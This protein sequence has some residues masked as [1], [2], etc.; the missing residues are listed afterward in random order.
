MDSEFPTLSNGRYKI[1]KCIGKGG[2]AAVFKCFDQ[3]LQVYRAVK[4]L[5]PDMVGRGNIRERFTTE[6]IAMANLVHPNIVH[7]YDH[8]LDG[9]AL[10]I[11]MEYLPHNSLQNFLD[12]NG[13]LS[14]SQAVTLMLD[15][16]SAVKKAHDNGIIHRDIK[17]DNILL[18][19]QGAKLTDF[20]LARI[21][22][23]DRRSTKTKAVMGTF[24]YMAPEQRLSAKK[25]NHQSDVYAVAASFFVMLTGL[26]PSD[27]FDEEEQI[28]LLASLNDSVKSIIRK[29]CQ[30]SLKSRYQN[31]DEFLEDLT[32]IEIDPNDKKLSL[33][34]EEVDAAENDITDLMSVWSEYTGL[35]TTEKETSPSDTLMFD[36]EAEIPED[37]T[38]GIGQS[39][40]ENSNN[41]PETIDT[42]IPEDLEDHKKNS[43]MLLVVFA[44]VLCLVGGLSFFIQ[45]L[46]KETSAIVKDSSEISPPEWNYEGIYL[47]VAPKTDADQRNFIAARRAMLN[48]EYPLAERLLAPLLK[49]HPEDPTTHSLAAILHV[50][51]G[52]MGMSADESRFAAKWSRDLETDLGK[53][54]Q[55]SDRSWREPEN[56]ENLISKWETIREKHNDPMVDISY[57]ISSRYMLGQKLFLSEV[58]QAKTNHPDWVVLISLEILALEHMG[59]TKELLTVV[60]NGIQ[61][62][63]TSTQLLLEKGKVLY[64][65]DK[66]ERAEEKLKEVLVLDG[67][68]ITARSLLAN[69]YI[70][71][72]KEAKRLEQFMISLG[73]TVAPFE[74][75]AFLQEHAIKLSNHGRLNEAEKVWRF[76]ISQAQEAKDYNRALECA[77]TALDAL[78]WIKPSK[79]WSRWTEELEEL[80][81]K[82]VYDADLRQ[83]YT[84]RLM[85]TEATMYARE[86]NVDKAKTILEQIQSLSEKDVPLNSKAFFVNEI[87]K[88]IALQQKDSETL[89]RILKQNQQSTS[90]NNC[91][92]L[93]LEAQIANALT[94]PSRIKNSLQRII[95]T[96]CTQNYAF[97]GLLVAKTRIWLAQILLNDWASGANKTKEVRLLVE[98]AKLLEAFNNEWPAADPSL[99]LMTIARALE[100][101]VK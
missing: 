97:N 23:S 82:P 85:W 37:E 81:A 36:L 50:L 64:K 1:E 13:T 6:A 62:F 24:P 52:R 88:E 48:G 25:T 16:G 22:T 18:S 68:L 56:R 11:V 90:E 57:L 73:D 98:A 71:Q 84:I 3:S 60:E 27:L 33:S 44:I 19:P 74:Q 28:E 75:L 76:C 10:F 42:P 40:G 79:E 21:D 61:S 96:E 86:G 26:D 34:N 89:E 58:R 80:L 49:S 77:S 100:E 55:L 35:S 94:D 91:S 30:A 17:P 7:V 70:E 78:P 9:S 15:V 2:M 46:N 8:G 14:L 41:P 4:I 31:M 5:R 72:N 51:R 20:G 99:E 12:K 63:P 39:I 92:V 67:N 47:L 43:N 38:I 45:D 93:F 53:L 83:F 59:K 29:G 32:G 54:L 87:Q 69:I 65:M 95:D 101:K 66:M